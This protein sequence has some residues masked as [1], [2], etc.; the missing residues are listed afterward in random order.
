MTFIVTRQSNYYDSGAYSVEIA[1]ARDYV[2]PG[3]LAGS[4]SEFEDSREAAECAIRLREDWYKSH[5]RDYRQSPLDYIPFTLAGSGALLGIYPTVG[6]GLTAGGLRRWAKDRYASLPKC[7]YCGEVCEAED[8]YTDGFG[9]H[10][11]A[12]SE[13]HAELQCEPSDWSDEEINE[14]DCW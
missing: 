3:A 10:F 9:D 14:T 8:N 2:S 1:S 11:T 12:C 5:P 13:Y 7:D 6:D 4:W